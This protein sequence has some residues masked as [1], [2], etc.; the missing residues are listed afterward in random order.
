[1]GGVG[2]MYYPYNLDPAAIRRFNPNHNKGI[3]EVEESVIGLTV[4]FGMGIKTHLGK[5]FGIGLEVL[6]RK[7]FNDKLDNLDDPLAHTN[8]TGDISYT[9]FMHNNDYTAYL[10]INITYKIFLGKEVC[11]A[12]ESKN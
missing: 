11:P 10:G 8:P 3:A 1:M 2:V 5:R 6:F 9:D 7:L 4:P 12:Y